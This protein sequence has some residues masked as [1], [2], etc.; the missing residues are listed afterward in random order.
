MILDIFEV[1]FDANVLR[2]LKFTLV[3]ETKL[4][5]E[6]SFGLLVWHMAGAL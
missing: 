3:L 4:A 6:V 5:A 1:S 2:F